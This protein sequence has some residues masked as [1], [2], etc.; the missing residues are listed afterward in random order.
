MAITPYL[1]FKG[2]CAEALKYYAKT[3]G[4]EIEMMMTYGEMP[5][6]EDAPPSNVPPDAIM[7]A[8]LKLPQGT[9]LASDDMGPTTSHGMSGF[10]LT[11]TYPTVEEATRI[12]GELA[13]GAQQIILPIGKTFWSEAFGMLNDRYGTP[14][15]VYAESPDQKS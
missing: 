7:H 13:Q 6:G 14:W 1:F 10:M 4:G 8:S 2:T 5:P 11:L 9:I 15:M 3:L 12:Y